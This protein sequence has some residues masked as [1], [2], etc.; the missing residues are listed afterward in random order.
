MEEALVLIEENQSWIYLGLGLFGLIYLRIAVKRYKDYKSTF[1][2]LERDRARERLLQSSL[3]LI[4]V[5]VGLVVTFLAATFGGPAVPVS[6]RPTVL[7]TVSLLKTPEVESAGSQAEVS[8]TPVE[9]AILE[10]MGCGNPDAT[11]TSPKDG[12]T[13]NNVVDVIG[14][15]NIPG[16]AFYKVEI[17]GS[18]TQAMWQAIGA[19][20]EPIC[21]NCDI[22][23]PLARWDTSLVIPGEYLLRLTVMDSIGNAPLPCEMKVRVLP[24]N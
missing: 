12:D 24:A 3:M 20:N 22:E 6:A 16:F 8:S 18:T 13:I 4:I 5:A 17:R 14:T 10:G 9:S 11:I 21:E 7:P 1:F 23:G 19:G 2:G 15:A